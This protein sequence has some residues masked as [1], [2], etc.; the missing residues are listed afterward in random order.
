MAMDQR[1][2]TMIPSSRTFE[3]NREPKPTSSFQELPYILGGM[4]AGTIGFLAG[5]W[6]VLLIVLFGLFLFFLYFRPTIGLF[7]LPFFVLVDYY[8]KSIG[9]G[10]I[11][12]LWDEVLF[13]VI[14]FFVLLERIRNNQ[15]FLRFTIVLY[16][17]LFFAFIGLLSAYFSDAVTL[18]QAIE[19]VRSVL[20]SFLFFFLVMNASL[21]KTQIR[22]LLFAVVLGGVICAIYGMVQYFVGVASPPTWVDKDLEFGLSRAFSFLGSPNAFSAYCI[23]IAPIALGFAFQS[24]TK[25]SHKVL[26][27]GLFLLLIGGLISTLTRAS[28]LAFIPALCVFFI[29]MKKGSYV[30]LVFIAMIC[31]LLFVPPIQQRFST[32]FSEQYQQKSAE[33]GRTYRWS[34]ALDLVQQK[35]FLGQG[36]GSYGGAVAYRFQEYGGLYSD[37]YYLQILSNYGVLGFIGFLF[38]LIFLMRLLLQSFRHASTKDKSI[39]A[40]IVCG[41]I[42]LFLNMYTENLWEIIPL[43]VVFCFFVA[44]GIRLGEVDDSR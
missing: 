26:F 1:D 5:G 2:H 9:V 15:K 8:V 36:P 38:I 10:G 22:A 24:S 35:P 17:I 12:G 39:I 28:W 14:F 32:L 23:M 4:I 44:L 27:W 31:I 13:L 21:K 19:A 43:S 33:G 29:L 6:Q 41:A 25:M 34:L 11:F 3:P 40:G 7:L 18:S 42:A 20:Q 30:I 37:N 16:P